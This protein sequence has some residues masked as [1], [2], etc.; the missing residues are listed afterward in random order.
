MLEIER[1]RVTNY[2]EYADDKYAAHCM[3]FTD[4][5]SVYWFSY[6]TLV[7]FRIKGEFHIRK[8][9]WGTITGKHLNWICKDKTIRE[10]EEV[11]NENYK[12]CIEK[13]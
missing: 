3:S 13:H 12:R 5:D 11:F 7:A 10:D 6:N 8:N 4:G 1:V 2:G 9:I